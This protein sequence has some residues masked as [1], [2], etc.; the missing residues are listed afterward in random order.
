LRPTLIYRPSSIASPAG[1]PVEIGALAWQTQEK[2]KRKIEALRTV[3][4][5]FTIRMY[6]LS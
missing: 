4:T 1:D 6:D 3:M 2:R 5:E